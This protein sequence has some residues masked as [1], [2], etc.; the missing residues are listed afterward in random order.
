MIT[1]III[2]TAAAAVVAVGRLWQLIVTRPASAVDSDR[3]ANMIWIWLPASEHL[4]PHHDHLDGVYYFAPGGGLHT[5][6]HWCSL[7]RSSTVHCETGEG[8]PVLE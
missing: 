7:T 1:I 5:F 2:I 4:P 6:S 8:Q 3:L